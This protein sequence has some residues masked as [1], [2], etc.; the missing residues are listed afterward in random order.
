MVE[1]KEEDKD[2]RVRHDVEESWLE[3]SVVVAAVTADV[4]RQVLEKEI[5]EEEE[6]LATLASRSL[7][8]EDLL[9]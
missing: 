5:K 4:S 7:M 8:R 3:G 1:V 6:E 9:G 2:G